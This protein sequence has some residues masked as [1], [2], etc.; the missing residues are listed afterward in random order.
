MEWEQAAAR[1]LGLDWDV[2][3]FCPEGSI[4][5]SE[6]VVYAPAIGVPDSR[7]A[8]LV[9]WLRVKIAY[10]K[11]LRERMAEV[12][13]FMLRYYVHDP[14]QL[15]FLLTCKKP[16]VLVHHTL[17]V[18]ELSLQGQSGRIRAAL[19]WAL[20]PFCI[21]AASLIAGV[22][23]EIVSYELER[24]NARAKPRLTYPNG[25]LYTDA[26]VIDDRADGPEIIFVAGHF[27]AW[28]GLDLLLDALEASSA[29][30]VIHLV[31]QLSR[32][33][34]VRAD[35]DLRIRCHGVLSAA[36]IRDIS[37]RCSLGLSSLALHRNKMK[38]AC[39]LKVREYLMMGLPVYA[40]YKDVF[41][42]D[43]PFFKEGAPDL[44]QIVE[45]AKQCAS[46]S[47]EEVSSQSR[48]HI[49][50]SIL[51][52]QFKSQLAEALGGHMTI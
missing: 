16:V 31:G 19:E 25:I 35:R 33:D 10:Y 27:S 28:H 1:Q 40:A 36:A 14:F 44:D 7:L 38:E 5:R 46:F 6:V 34:Q 39:T 42:T 12:D 52:G 2:R 47:R 20:G 43:F 13:V 26:T 21:R 8:K 41:P 9:T 29:N 18:P 24:S 11:W 15:L 32:E 4:E 49:E 3:I 17:E 48:V 23:N 51:L 50:K 22:T 37:R 45:Y 30:C